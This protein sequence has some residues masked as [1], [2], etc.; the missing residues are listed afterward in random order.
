MPR[1]R[2]LPGLLA[3]VVIAPLLA[4]CSALGIPDAPTGAGLLAAAPDEIDPA[5][6]VLPEPSPIQVSSN[7]GYTL[8][9]P[10]G[11]VGARAN[12]EVTRAALDALSSGDVVLGEEASALLS[13]ADGD[14]SLVAAD[15][16]EVGL[17]AVPPVLAILVIPSREGSEDTRQRLD[18]MIGSLA[19]VIGEIEH[20]V[21]SVRAGDAQRYDLTVAGDTLT[22]QLRVY[23]FTIGD[24]GI[25]ILF[26]S[27]PAIAEDASADM[28]AIVKS[29]RFGV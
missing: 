7:D 15:T 27:D 5:A 3:A 13:S 16:A 6:T 4:G 20:S 18:D 17:T 28:E 21:T 12:D 8:T 11:W 14:L 24:D 26:G 22:V 10:A 19:T 23:L 9:L 1:I 2:V 29:L 25:I